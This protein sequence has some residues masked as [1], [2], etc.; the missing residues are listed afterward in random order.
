M[1]NIFAVGDMAKATSGNMTFVATAIASGVTAA[2]FLDEDIFARSWDSPIS[3]ALLK[4]R[5]AWS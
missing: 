1:P 5:I 2:A 3:S 4:G